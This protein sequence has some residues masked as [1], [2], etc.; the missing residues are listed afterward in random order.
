VTKANKKN[1]NQEPEV[2]LCAI[3]ARIT[4]F[5]EAEETGYG[6]MVF[7]FNADLIGILEDLLKRGAYKGQLKLAL[8]CARFNGQPLDD[9]FFFALEE[10]ANGNI[11]ERV[12]EEMEA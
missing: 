1:K 8:K 9:V 2:M 10:L 3:E 5:L 11:E 6:A 4:Q 7:D 12:Q